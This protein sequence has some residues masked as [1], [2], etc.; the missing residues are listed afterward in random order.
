M[1][2]KQNHKYIKFKLPKQSIVRFIWYMKLKI[3]II[4]Y[5]FLLGITDNY[6]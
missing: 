4:Y 6:N 2:Q 3:H 5:V 1:N